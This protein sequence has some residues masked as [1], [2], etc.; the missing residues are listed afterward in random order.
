M[1]LTFRIMKTP[2]LLPLSI[3][4]VVVL[5]SNTE[6]IAAPRTYLFVHGAWGGGWEYQQMEALLTAKG[7]I[8]Y[9]PTMTGLGERVHLADPDIGLATHIADIVNVILFE[10]L[11]D[12]ILIGHSYGGMVITGVANKVPERIRQMVY[13]DAFVPDDGESVFT[14][15]GP[16]GDKMTEPFTKDGFVDY[17]FGP[18]FPVPPTDVPQPLRTFT[19]TIEYDEENLIGIPTIFILMTSREGNEVFRPFSEKAKK[20]GWKV[21]TLEGGH[22][23]MR[24]QP[25]N[26]AELLE[27]CK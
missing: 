8:V 25:S 4:L 20:K 10:N 21:F 13:I 23:P 7:D 17:F 1:N 19:D 26:L 18:T 3:M 6:S 27:N 14:S 11:T 12:V 16:N 24:D 2:F 15:L 9:R 5:F 22:Y